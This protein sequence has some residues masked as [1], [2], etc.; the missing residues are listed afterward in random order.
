[1]NY[2]L[3]DI[4]EP[5]LRSKQ[6]LEEEKFGTVIRSNSFCVDSFHT[7]ISCLPAVANISE[8]LLKSINRLNLC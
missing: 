8:E 6:R 5:A 3:P 2:R 7:R 4:I 1:M